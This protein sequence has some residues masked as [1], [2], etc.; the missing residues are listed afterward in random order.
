MTSVHFLSSYEDL[1]AGSYDMNGWTFN[2][3]GTV[4]LM[5]TAAS[6]DEAA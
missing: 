4:K 2:M 6:S 3:Q 5:V 1:A